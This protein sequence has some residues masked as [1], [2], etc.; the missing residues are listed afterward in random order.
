MNNFKSH[1]WYTKRQRNGIFWLVII[2]VLLQ[3]LLFNLERFY[4]E[5]ENQINEQQVLFLQNKI[6]SLRAASHK[7]SIKIYP[8]N[9][10]F[11]SDYKGYTLGMSVEEIDRLHAF[12]KINKYVN[13]KKEFQ[14]VTGVSDSLLNAIAPYFK[15]PDWVNAKKS[16]NKTNYLSNNKW[17]NTSKLESRE[18]TTTDINLATA[19]DFTVIKGIG[20]KRS[21]Q[22]IR[23]RNKLQGFS[24]NY[25]LYELWNMPPELITDVLSVFKIEN[26]PQIKK[27][28]VNTAAFKEVLK[29]PYVDYELCKKI[30]DYRDEVAELQNITELKNIEGFPINKYDLIALYLKVE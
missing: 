28:N 3:V 22:I 7:K 12:R 29:T 17:S 24:Y 18:P 26:K 16:A 27:V 5:K 1:F 14:K 2:V 30:F 10:N 21:E 4:P 11:I 6:D 13:S 20:E 25:Q 9:P 23:Y 15:F 8:F 19:E